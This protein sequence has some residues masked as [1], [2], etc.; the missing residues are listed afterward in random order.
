MRTPMPPT[1]D[2]LGLVADATRT[3]AEAART[4]DAQAADARRADLEA[5]RRMAIIEPILREAVDALHRLKV[6]QSKLSLGQC[7]IGGSFAAVG[8]TESTH[9]AELSA[10]GHEIGLFKFF[11]GGNFKGWRLPG[12]ISGGGF[13][14]ERNLRIWAYGDRLLTAFVAGEPRC[15]VNEFAFAPDTGRIVIVPDDLRR[16]LAESVARLAAEH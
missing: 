8:R 6:R 7:C 15:Y 14:L 3:A 9:R 16:N 13:L 4:S 11:A 1:H 10:Y 12:G 2:F 5:E